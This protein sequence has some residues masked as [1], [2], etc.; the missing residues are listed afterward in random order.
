MGV[1]NGRV[2]VVAGCRRWLSSLVVVAGCRRWSSSLVVV[3]GCRRWL[4]KLALE[5][6]HLADATTSESESYDNY[7]PNVKLRFS[8]GKDARG[9]GGRVRASVRMCLGARA[10][11][12][13]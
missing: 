11:R 8:S 1:G 5:Q 2:V 10:P 12:K 9:I 13:G 7:P 4:S 3:A 6:V